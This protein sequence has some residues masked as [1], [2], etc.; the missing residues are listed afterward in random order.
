MLLPISA[1]VARVRAGADPSL[2]ATLSS[3]HAVLNERQ[4]AA[5][6]GSCLL[7]PDP[8][9]ASLNDLDA[10]ARARFLADLGH[11]GDAILAVT[12]AER[13]NYL[14]LCNQV[15]ELHAHCI[16]RFGDEDPARRGLGP[17]EAYDFAG[18]PALEVEGEHRELHGALVAALRRFTGRVVER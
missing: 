7:L 5:L 13:I 18:A 16:P 2:L 12:G 8:V 14:I 10:A 15:P 1:R 3:G 4:P 17:F 11:L 9:V 6:R